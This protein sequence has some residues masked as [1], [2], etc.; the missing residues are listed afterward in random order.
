MH[1]PQDYRKLLLAVSAIGLSLGISGQAISQ[2]RP[3]F[4][5]P[6]A[7]DM[8]RQNDRNGDGRLDSSEI[9]SNPF[10][11]RMLERMG[12]DTSRGVSERD[13]V[14]RM[15]EMRRN[16]ER[17]GGGGDRGRGDRG[18][19]DRR[20]DDE[21]RGGDDR[22]RGDDD[23]DDRNRADEDAGDRDSEEMEDDESS[24]RTPRA[25]VTVDL[26]EDLRP[27]DKD[28]DGQIAFYE[29]RAW[30]G[31]SLSEFTKLD[32]NGDGFITPREILQIRGPEPDEQAAALAA[33]SRQSPGRDGAGRPSSDDDRSRDDRDQTDTAANPEL[34]AEAQRYF[35]LMDRNRDGSVAPDEWQGRRIRGMFES[36]GIDLDEPVSS[37]DFVRHYVRLSA[38]N[39]D[40]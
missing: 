11:P 26:Q 20:R 39:A 28:Q 40:R 17:N 27:G 6:S 3:R 7:Q 35:D 8:F 25:R 36:D 16:F 13:F 1:H 31:K 29:W 37:E 21:N 12:V 5:M 9:N 14:G 30:E 24:T 4:Q 38:S 33:N 2:E 18:D 32:L 22:R 23:R 19:G 15:D 10:L 34:A